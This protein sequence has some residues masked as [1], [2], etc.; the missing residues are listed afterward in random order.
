MFRFTNSTMDKMLC[1]IIVDAWGELPPSLHRTN[2]WA[3]I[4]LFRAHCYIRSKHLD[5]NIP[6]LWVDTLR[7]PIPVL[8]LLRNFFF[9]RLC[10]VSAGWKL[11][12]VVCH[13]CSWCETWKPFLPQGDTH[14]RYTYTN[15]FFCI[16]FN[17]S[18][19]KIC[20]YLFITLIKK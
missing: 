10:S 11:C 12:R 14:V 6:I 13:R 4:T 19:Y 17:I 8:N 16:Y 9:D 18:L 2:T 3:N 5:L 1:G 15:V 7:R 20:W